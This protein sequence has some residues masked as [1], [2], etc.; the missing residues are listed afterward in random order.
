MPE[1]D[2]N[3]EES[4]SVDVGVEGGVAL[5]AARNVEGTLT[6]RSRGFWE[7]HE[8]AR[9]QQSVIIRFPREKGVNTHK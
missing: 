7:S 9:G 4:V 3:G 6:R 1:D 8:G 2:V 5:V